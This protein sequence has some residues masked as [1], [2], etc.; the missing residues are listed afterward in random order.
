VYQTKAQYDRSNMILTE[1]LSSPLCQDVLSKDCIK[2]IEKM[3]YSM[4]DKETY[5]AFYVQKNISMSFDA[6]TTS[7]AE[8]M[9][10]SIKNGMGVNSNSNTR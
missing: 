4:I 5:L 3:Q 9:N 7:P 8:S 10:S 6:M 2:A 1:M